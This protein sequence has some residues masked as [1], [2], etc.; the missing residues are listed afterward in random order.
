M[1][2]VVE[3]ENLKEALAQ[4]KAQQGAAGVDGM[5]HW[6][7]ARLPEGALACDRTAT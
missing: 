2:D 3:R 7:I 6:R 4:V 1:E 5:T